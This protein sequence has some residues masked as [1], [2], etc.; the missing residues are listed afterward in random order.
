MKINNYFFGYLKRYKILHIINLANLF[1]F[2]AIYKGN[3]PFLKWIAHD[4]NHYLEA[5]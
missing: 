5:F 3:F 1:D 4:N 2:P